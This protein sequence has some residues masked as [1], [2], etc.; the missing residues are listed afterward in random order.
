[1]T[2]I[3]IKALNVGKIWESLEF[4][5][6]TPRIN[7]SKFILLF[8]FWGSC[9]IIVNLLAECFKYINQTIEYLVSLGGLILF[10]NLLALVMRRLNDFNRSATW[11]FVGM[12]PII[13]S[14][15]FLLAILFWPGTAGSNRYGSQPN[16][17]PKFYYLM[18]L[19]LVIIVTLGFS[20][21]FK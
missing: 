14:I 17:T 15:P 12:V 3:S 6:L 10:A 11:A 19:P 5:C 2:S 21:N 9:I 13:G 4:Y 8:Q 20:I 16:K 7:R 1:M 18:L